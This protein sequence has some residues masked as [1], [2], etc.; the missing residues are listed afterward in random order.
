MLR[1]LGIEKFSLSAFQFLGITT[2]RLD[3]GY[4]NEEIVR[5][6]RNSQKIRIQL[7]AST[8]TAKTLMEL[9]QSQANFSNI[10]ALHNFYPREATGLSE[11]TLVR[12][13]AMLHK[14]GIKVGAFIPSRNRRRSPLKVGLPTL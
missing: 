7:N 4:S 1:L 6:S 9:L 2:L 3:D 8:I 11:E 14:A 10:D 12:K 13:N 5:L